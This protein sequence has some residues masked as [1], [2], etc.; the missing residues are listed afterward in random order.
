[1]AVCHPSMFY[2]FFLML[3][4][5]STLFS[6]RLGDVTSQPCNV[7]EGP[8]TVIESRVYYNTQLSEK[9]KK[10]CQRIFCTKGAFAL[11]PV[12]SPLAILQEE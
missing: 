6:F 5:F 8:L 2:P 11:L 1:M 9:Y 12:A 7:F 3:Y 4:G 10:Y